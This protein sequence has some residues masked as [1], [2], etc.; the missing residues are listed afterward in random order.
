MPKD[1]GYNAIL[2]GVVLMMA[3]VASGTC[4]GVAGGPGQLALVVGLMTAGAA[5]VFVGALRNRR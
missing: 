4:L 1:P 3:G 5:L 2:L